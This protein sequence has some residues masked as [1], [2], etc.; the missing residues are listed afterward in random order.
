MLLIAFAGGAYKLVNYGFFRLIH[1]GS[2]IASYEQLLNPY[3]S[4]N[5]LFHASLPALA[6]LFVLFLLRDHY[7]LLNL[8]VPGG[9][10]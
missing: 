4:Y 3:A 6:A 7:R 9:R 10:G 5:H 8:P 2:V 1:A